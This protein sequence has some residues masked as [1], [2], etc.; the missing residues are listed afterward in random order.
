[1]VVDVVSTAKRRYMWY[2][3]GGT[4]SREGIRRLF[5]LNATYGGRCYLSG[6]ET[7][8]MVCGRWSKQP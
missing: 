6:Q 8:Y 2:L 5:A 3:I 1:M 7:L 4:S